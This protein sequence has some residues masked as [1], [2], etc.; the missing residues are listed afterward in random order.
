LKNRTSVLSAL[1][2]ALCSALPAQADDAGYSEQWGPATGTV[3]PMLS[4]Q[5][6]SGATRTVADLTGSSG[7]LLMLVRSADW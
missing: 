1:L 7:M 5:D 4:A 6:Q 2:L 3:L